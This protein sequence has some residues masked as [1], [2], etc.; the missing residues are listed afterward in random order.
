MTRTGA[1]GTACRLYVAMHH[2]DLVMP[3]SCLGE[4]FCWREDGM[5]V[6]VCVISVTVALSITQPSLLGMIFA[7]FGV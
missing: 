3:D 2:V 7:E 6:R 5:C 4:V 1:G